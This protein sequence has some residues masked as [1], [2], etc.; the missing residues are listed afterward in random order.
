MKVPVICAHD[1]VVLIALNVTAPAALGQEHGLPPMAL[2][3][4]RNNR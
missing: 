4:V 3:M 1:I 2:I